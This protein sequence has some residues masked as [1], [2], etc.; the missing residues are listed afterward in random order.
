MW[1]LLIRDEVHRLTKLMV[2]ASVIGASYITW[3]LTSLCVA[4]FYRAANTRAVRQLVI[5]MPGALLLELSIK[6]LVKRPRPEPFFG[7]PLPLSYSFPSGHA[8]YSM[9]C[10][11]MLAT[12]IAPLIPSRAGRALF[13][14]ATILLVAA[15]GFSRIYL[16]VHYPSDVLGGYA[17]GVVWV[18]VVKKLWQRW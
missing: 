3:P 9:A 11:G 6:N 7:Y 5:S 14:A 1:D 16:G 13:W 17:L 18:L 15:I 12:L 2:A 4:L 8:L 10:Y